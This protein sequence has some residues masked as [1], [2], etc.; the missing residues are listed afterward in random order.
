MDSHEIRRIM[1]RAEELSF[2]RLL[3]KQPTELRHQQLRR[4]W[5]SLAAHDACC[6]DPE[7]CSC[8]ASRFSSHYRRP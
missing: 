4:L 7:R 8:G 2:A 1:R 6:K 3:K 5:A